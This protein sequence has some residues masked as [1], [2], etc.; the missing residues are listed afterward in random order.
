MVATP[1]LHPLPL[2]A[3]LASLKGPRAETVS[4]GDLPGDRF[5]VNLGGGEDKE[6]SAAPAAGGGGWGKV[7]RGLTVRRKEVSLRSPLLAFLHSR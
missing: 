5:V 3:Q 6:S 1:A 2:P 4:Q 7:K